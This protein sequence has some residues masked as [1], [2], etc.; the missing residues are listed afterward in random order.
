MVILDSPPK[1]KFMSW[2]RKTD[3]CWLWQGF[4][5]RQGYGNTMING[6]TTK[7]HRWSY[8]LF[9]GPIGPFCVCHS[10]DNPSCVNPDHLWL[11][12]KKQNAIDREVKGRNAQRL[13]THCPDGHEYNEKNTYYWRGYRACRPCQLRR[14]HERKQITD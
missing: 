2:V 5:N 14:Y 6:Y 4:L 10:C 3:D 7:A 11:G 9:K 1:I 8:L 13:K 12:T